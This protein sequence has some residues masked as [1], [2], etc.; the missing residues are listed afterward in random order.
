MSR[1]QLRAKQRDC[2]QLQKRQAEKAMNESNR[3]QWYRTPLDKKT[4]AQLNARSDFKGWLQSLG[5]LGLLAT[6]GALAL[7]GAGRWPIWLVAL[8][9]FC[10]VQATPS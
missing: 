1:L 10:T 9:F 8:M 6:T 7:Y 2:N 3:V 5:H 4:M